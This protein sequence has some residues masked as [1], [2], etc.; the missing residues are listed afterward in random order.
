MFSG[1]S[2]FNL[3]FSLMKVTRIKEG[4]SIEIRMDSSN[5]LN[6]PTWDVADQT[7]SSTNFGRVTSTFYGRRLI[8]LSARYRF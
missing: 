2:T 4:Q 5:V 8:Q 1:P 3:D 6:H 7:I